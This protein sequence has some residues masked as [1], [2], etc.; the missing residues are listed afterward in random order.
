VYIGV[1]DS[2]TNRCTRCREWAYDGRNAFRKRKGFSQVLGAY[3]HHREFQG[4]VECRTHNVALWC[5]VDRAQGPLGCLPKRTFTGS[6]AHTEIIV[7]FGKVTNVCPHYLSR[8]D[9]VRTARFYTH[10]R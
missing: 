3:Q 1:S 7:D 9:H 10:E 5:D 8:A 6:V 4:G 2:E